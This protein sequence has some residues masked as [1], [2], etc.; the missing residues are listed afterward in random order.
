MRRIK[1]IV[2]KLGLDGHDR[3][4]KVIARALA[5]A[6]MDVVYTG[7]RQTPRQ[8]VETAVQE[9]ADVVGISILSGSHLELVKELMDEMRRRG[10]DIP[11]MVGGIIPPEDEES[12]KQMGVAEVFGPGTPL[13]IIVDKVRSLAAVRRV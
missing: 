11:V 13:S 2:A 7:M 5:E 4:A 3:G 9:D 10:I 6:G 1:V 12:L 8:V